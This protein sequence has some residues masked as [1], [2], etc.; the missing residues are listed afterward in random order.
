MYGIVRNYVHYYMNIIEGSFCLL[1]FNHPVYEAINNKDHYSLK[2]HNI[3]DQLI[4]T[5]EAIST[6]TVL[7]V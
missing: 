4:V 6:T 5:F 7:P 3:V 1:T 2:I